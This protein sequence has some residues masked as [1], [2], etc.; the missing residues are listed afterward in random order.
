[1]DE[2]QGR[3]LTTLQ[4]VDSFTEVPF[5]GNPA[6]VTILEEFP[7]DSRMQDIAREMN[8]SETAFVVRRPDGDHDLRWFTPSDEVDLC[9]H[10]TLASAHVLGG[11]AT[12][13]TKSGALKCDAGSDGMI[14]MDFPADPPQ[15]SQVP[16][17]LAGFMPLSCARGRFDLVVE[18]TDPHAVRSF[19]PDLSAIT[20]IDCR[21]LIITARGG[22]SGIDFTSRV[23]APAV[24]IPEDP[25]TGSAHCTLAAFWGEQIGRDDLIGYQASLRGG[26][27]HMRRSAARVALGGHAVTVSEVRLLVAG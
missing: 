18:L 26:T 24:G 4:V 10:A 25:V 11:N 22:P 9:G 19:I 20:R 21:G 1:V 23:F 13:H 8:L 16:A 17:E 6:A 15:P 5:K 14:W 7:A 3:A 12:F 2:R 27:V